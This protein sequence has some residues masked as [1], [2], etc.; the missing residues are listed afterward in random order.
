MEGLTET[1]KQIVKRLLDSHQTI[2]EISKVTGFK[3]SSICNYI[4]YNGY[5]YNRSLQIRKEELWMK[6]KALLDEGCTY[7]EVSIKCN[8]SYKKVHR[9]AKLHG[10]D[11]MAKKKE[12]K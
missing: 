6:M 12:A 1:E 7:K 3:R 5:D 8:V 4:Y 10:Y 9:Y 11:Y 2:D